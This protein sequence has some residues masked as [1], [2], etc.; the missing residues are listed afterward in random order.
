VRGRAAEVIDAQREKLR[1][2]LGSAVDGRD[3]EAVHDMRVASRRLRAAV[4]VFAPWLERKEVS[5]IAP[6]VRTLTRALGAVR[7]L[8]V[9]RLRLEALARRARPERRLAIE[10]VDA[11][12]ARRRRR[13]RARM[14]RRFAAV[15]LDDLDQRLQRLVREIE[16][17][18]THLHPRGPGAPPA[19]ET[20]PAVPQQAL[21]QESGI[22]AKASA[23]VEGASS[24]NASD[25]RPGG[26]SSGGARVADEC[27]DDPTA[28]LRAVEEKAVTAARGVT[29]LSSVEGHAI[30]SVAGGEALHEVRI[31]AKKL[32][33][34]L[35]IVTPFVG[36]PAEALVHRLKAL[37]DILGDFHDDGVLNLTLDEGIRRAV[38]RER[39]LLAAELRKLRRTRRR[40]LMRDERACRAEIAALL[41]SGF[42]EAVAAA[43]TPKASGAEAVAR[44]TEA[45]STS[46][47]S[48]AESEASEASRQ[49]A[50]TPG[51]N[52]LRVGQPGG[53]S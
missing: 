25:P 26:D 22:T 33:Y 13:A 34:I 11:R 32:R 4:S 36:A 17:A 19:H 30:G 53:S 3:P 27:A 21:A 50:D 16:T 42:A 1:R 45:D 46:T 5:R 15:D 49:E 2:H 48:R 44:R 29:A 41:A 8:D 12:L 14:M 40:V 52:A 47:E 9:T 51:A 35:E 43:L 38:E 24:D 23:S 31:H 28:L 18:A 7:E 37:Q 10:A 6:A 39:P 20:V